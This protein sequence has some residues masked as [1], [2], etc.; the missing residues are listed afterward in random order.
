MK[1]LLQILVPFLVM[2]FKYLFIVL[3]TIL[4]ISSISYK[5]LPYICNSL[6]FYKKLSIFYYNL[7]FEKDGVSTQ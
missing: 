1:A 2:L 3:M 7:K 4:F 6:H 5:I